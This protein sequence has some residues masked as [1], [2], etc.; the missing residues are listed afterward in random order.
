MKIFCEYCGGQFEAER[1]NFCP[2]CGAAFSDNDQIEHQIRHE[3]RLDELEIEQQKMD[4][5][6]RQARIHNMNENKAAGRRLAGIGCLVPILL[7]VVAF[8]LCLAAVFIVALV[9]VVNE[10]KAER[11]QEN[12]EENRLLSEDYEYESTFE[13][14][15]PVS[16]GFNEYAETVNYSVICDSF[17]QVDRYPFG[18]AEGYMYVNF[19]I[20]VKNTGIGEVD[21]TDDIMCLVDGIMMS[22]TWYSDK[23]EMPYVTLPAGVSAEGNACFE[24]PVDA[25]EF[26]LRYGEYVTI[27]IENTLNTEE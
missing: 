22:E 18:A 2:N 8:S 20:V 26:E 21:T 3:Q 23:K 7:P 25:E 16:A 6:E 24:V 5:R 27:Y 14:D 4:L 15:I 1:A 19:H 12:E 10:R 13:E 9:D 17:E 11:Q